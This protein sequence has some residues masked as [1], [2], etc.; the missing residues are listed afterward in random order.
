MIVLKLLLSYMSHSH[1]KLHSL[2]TGRPRADEYQCGVALCNQYSLEHDNV[3]VLLDHASCGS[4]S[5]VG[6]T[7]ADRHGRVEQTDLGG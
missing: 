1:F 2:N 6:L 5:M 7:H 4:W 3:T